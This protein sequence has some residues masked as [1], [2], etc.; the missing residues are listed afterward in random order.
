MNMNEESQSGPSN[1]RSLDEKSEISNTK[2]RKH[3]EIND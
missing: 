2:K 1:K 3:S